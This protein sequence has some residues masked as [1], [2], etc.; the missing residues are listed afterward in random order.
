MGTSTDQEREGG[1]GANTSKRKPTQPNR[2]QPK[3]TQAN[4]S[5]PTPRQSR[6]DTDP[7]TGGHRHAARRGWEGLFPATRS[8]GGNQPPSTGR[9]AKPQMHVVRAIR[10]AAGEHDAHEHARAEARGRIAH[11][12]L[13]EDGEFLTRCRLA[14]NSPVDKRCEHHYRRQVARTRDPR[15]TGATRAG[16]GWVGAPSFLATSK[17]R[18]CSQPLGAW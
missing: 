5:Q 14:R 6:P 11:L 16:L 3:P 2:S 15:A 17:H 7:C 8:M 13:G 10:G 12:C 9:L 1:L 18:G 4:S